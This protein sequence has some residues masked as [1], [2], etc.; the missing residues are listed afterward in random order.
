VFLLFL[1]PALMVLSLAA[2]QTTGGL[3]GVLT[4]DSGAVIPAA[5]IS[6]TGNGATK[7]V[8]T[9]ADGSYST[10]GLAPGQ[11]TVRVSYPGFVPVD[12]TVAVNAGGSVQVMIQ[13]AVKAEKQ[14]VTV[15][16]EAGPSVSV[17]PD[18]NATALVLKGEDLMALPDDPDDLADA[19]QAL[20]GPAAGPNGGQIYIDGFSG[21]QLPPKESIREIRINQN[22]FSAEFDHLGF[23]RIEILTRPGT[24]RYR[25]SFGFN[26]SD[27]IFNSRNPYVNNKPDFSNRMWSANIGGPLGHKTSFFLDFNRRQITDNAIVNAVYLDPASLVQQPIQTAVVTPNY[28]TTIAPRFDY[29]ITHNNTLIVRFE[30]GWNSRDN[31]GI[32]G[33]SLPPPYANE[34]YNTNG[35]Q[36]NLMVTE[37]SV[38]NNAIVNE[39]RFQ[40]SRNYNQSNGN[41]LPQINVSGAFSAGGNGLGL[42]FTR[43]HHYELQNLTTIAHH[44][45]TIR[46]GVRVRREGYINDSPQNFGGSFYFNGGIGPVLDANNQPVLDSSG[47]PE[48]ENLLAI[49]QY[50]RTLLFQGLGDT[51]AQIRAL[52]GMPSQF[53]IQTGNP[54]GSVVYWDTAPWVLDDWRIKPNFTL[55]LG[56]RYEVQSNLNDHHDIAPRL[57]F[58][59]APGTAKT[60]RQ[61]TV[62]RGGFGLFYDRI[63][64]SPFLNVLELNGSYQ[65][66]YVVTN[67]NFYPTLPS[68]SSLTPTQNSIYLLDSK[69]RGDYLMQSAIGVERQLPKNSTIAVTYT[70]SR[71]VHEMQTVP[72]NTPLP[73]T[74]VPGVVG[75]GVRPYG[76]AGNLFEYESGGSLKQNILMT[77]FNTRFTRNLSLQGN[78]SYSIAHDLGSTP[79]DPYNFRADWGP[80]SFEH[81]HSFTMVGSWLAPEKISMSPFVTL[82]SG[83]PYDV[84]L[85][86]DL[87]GDTLTNARPALA[88]GPGTDVVCKAGFG[89]FNTN[90]SLNGP[91]VPR[92]YLTNAGLISLNLRIGRTFGFG[93]P[94]ARNNAMP[95]GGGG[96][97]MGGGPGGD[98]GG[99]GGR[100]GPGGGGFGGGGRGGAGGMGG[101]GG[102]G[103]P[104][105][106]GGG[107]MRMGGGGGGRGGFGGTN[108]SEHRYN[109]TLSVMFNNILNHTNPGG[110]VG[111]INSPQFGQP[112]TVNTGFGGGAGGGRGGGGTANN[113][114]VDMSMRFNF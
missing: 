39:T 92:G 7:T 30:E 15:A 71:G 14:E 77:N 16:A 28:R 112:T 57:G 6:I 38:L 85:G 114:R 93:A 101:G 103:G 91:F 17:E 61:K 69:L 1:I 22:P 21:G 33:R 81:K 10:V 25:G 89:C 105:G 24:D 72:I 51:P 106:G 53:T 107:G 47:N 87:F 78:Y 41:L 8:Q 104:G 23:G 27:G 45:H 97:D 36:Q 99:G 55:S 29:A 86:R 90:P 11:Y 100:G 96:G 42:T 4:D 70:N 43:Q 52:G 19:L 20:A 35:D 13:L 64:S 54:Y 26:D 58:A 32:S 9:Q 37:T 68:L 73:G 79:T 56:L 83:A 88:S 2:Q 76:N 46:F 50:R 44:T 65:L 18:N 59:W 110:F 48:T 82:R 3:R 49:E 40:Y 111:S 95:A 63:G 84:T 67:P 74:F 109:V 60:G 5:T 31:A 75:S 113:R 80:S 108:L 34:A 102:R 98:M 12:K 94:R 62:I 66:N